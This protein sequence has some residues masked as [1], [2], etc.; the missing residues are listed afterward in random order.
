MSSET[1]IILPELEHIEARWV[2]RIAILSF[3]VFQTHFR[4]TQGALKVESL[5]I[6]KEAPIKPC[7]SLT[8]FS[9]K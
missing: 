2:F 6:I 4:T 1:M 9:G 8:A 3:C 5:Q 7:H